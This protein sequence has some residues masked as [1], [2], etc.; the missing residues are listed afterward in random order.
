ML[1]CRYRDTVA[2][3]RLMTEFVARRRAIEIRCDEVFRKAEALYGV[4]LSK[5]AILFNLRGRVAGMACCRRH[6]L[7]NGGQAYD[8]RLRFNTDMIVGDGYEHILNDCVPH[9]I[10][11]LV[12]YAKP[13]LGSN[14]DRG[15]QRV[16]V[17]LGGNGERCH[18]EDVL[19]ARGN[20]YEYITST[21]AKIQ[22]GEK[23]HAKIQAG[24][25]LT[26]HGKIGGGTISRA[27]QYSVV[28]IN[29]RR[30]DAQ[31]VNP[32]TGP[33][34]VALPR[35]QPVAKTGV[36]RTVLVRAWIR[37]SVAQGHTQAWCEEVCGQ[38]FG[39]SRAQGKSYVQT[40]WLRAM[41][42]QD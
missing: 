2:K 32:V 29:G 24:R 9:E 26:A 41:T 17:A 16:C 6:R 13:E 34:S 35:R 1:L 11:H 12:C 39:M 15:W 36:A 42:T 19:Y 18:T 30:V 25:V 20:T 31:V 3:E 4:D 23:H 21:G 7:I 33:A 10:A 27:S 14:H 22:V 38:V 40:Q 28:G 37:D 8:L 5:T